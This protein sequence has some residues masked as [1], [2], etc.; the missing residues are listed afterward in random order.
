MITSALAPA[1]IPAPNQYSRVS[2]L[3]DPRPRF[4]L[5]ALFCWDMV[6]KSSGHRFAAD[7]MEIHGQ[8]VSRGNVVPKS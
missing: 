8:N 2:F 1:C 6:E 4:A 7:Q 5:F 3:R